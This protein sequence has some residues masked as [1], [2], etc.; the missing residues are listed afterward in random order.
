MLSICASSINSLQ[1]RNWE[2]CYSSCIPKWRLRSLIPKLYT[3]NRR[4]DSS[5]GRLQSHQNAPVLASASNEQEQ[6][7]GLPVIMAC[8][9]V[10]L[11]GGGADFVKTGFRDMAGRRALTFSGT[12]KIEHPRE[13]SAISLHDSAAL[14]LLHNRRRGPTQK[15]CCRIGRTGPRKQIPDCGDTTLRAR[16]PGV[17]SGYGCQMRW[18]GDPGAAVL[19]I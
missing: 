3:S 17:N 1:V 16:I 5:R 15:T 14:V 19:R 12:G 10:P 18:G 4:G 7:T 8:D 6:K 11:R 13:G 2:I 9:K